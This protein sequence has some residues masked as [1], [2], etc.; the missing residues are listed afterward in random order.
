MTYQPGIPTGSVPLNQDYLNLQANFSQINSQFLIDHVPLTSTSGSPPN[1][2]HT[3]IHLANQ[4][5]DPVASVSAGQIYSKLATIPPGGDSQLFFETPLGGVQQI[6]GHSALA[7]GYA[8]VS[9]ILIQWGVKATPGASG[10]IT[11]SAANVAFP[12]N[13]FSVQLTLSRA[14]ANSGSGVI[15]IDSG[16]TFDKATAINIR[17]IGWYLD[18]E[19]L[20][21]KAFIPGTNN[22]LDGGTSQQFRT[23]LRVVVTF[24]GLT[25]GLNSQPHGVIVDAN[26]SLIQLYGA[27]TNATAFTGEPIPNGADTITYDATNINITVA[28]AYTRAWAVMEYIQEL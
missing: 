12:N 25:I 6:S 8:W 10:T 22:I 1:G 2:Y 26:F 16:A 15:V 5:V 14:N 23:I 17:E 13:L 7:N 27:A 11:F 21:G 20:S 18:Q 24:P 28:A 3:V 4:T 19:L 9:G